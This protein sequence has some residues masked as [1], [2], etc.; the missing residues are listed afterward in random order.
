MNV[1][2]LMLMFVDKTVKRIRLH[3]FQDSKLCAEYIE[4]KVTLSEI[5]EMSH[6]VHEANL[7]AKDRFF[8]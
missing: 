3:L 1:L 6:I 2:A 7:W 8:K 5:C 4:I